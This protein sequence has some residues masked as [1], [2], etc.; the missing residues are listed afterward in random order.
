MQS[1]V[2]NIVTGNAE[3]DGKARRGWFVGDFINP[4][5]NPRSTAAVEVKWGNHRAG[6]RRGEWAPP[7]DSTTLSVLV[8]GR[9]C[10]QFPDE[11]IILASQGDYAL[12]LPGIAHSWYAEETSVVLSV[13]WIDQS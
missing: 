8:S 10:L 6:D 13:R 7:S 2:A 5:D 11:E 3:I 12:W 1:N 9:F 4:N